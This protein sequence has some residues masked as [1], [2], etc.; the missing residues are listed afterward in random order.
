MT[1]RMWM[2]LLPLLTACRVVFGGDVDDYCENE[3]DCKLGLV[4]EKLEAIGYYGSY[5]SDDPDEFVCTQA[6]KVEA[7]CPTVREDPCGKMPVTC[8]EGF[9][10]SRQNCD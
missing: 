1:M 8:E 7:D 3:K 10:R 6:C 9:C 5:D 4:C 2:L